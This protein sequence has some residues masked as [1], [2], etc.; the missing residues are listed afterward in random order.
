MGDVQIETG[1]SKDPQLYNMDYDIGQQ[2]NVAWNY[3]SVV[4]E[5][6]ERLRKIMES[7]STR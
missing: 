4:K 5:M 1:L 7:D 2:T 3:M 6:E